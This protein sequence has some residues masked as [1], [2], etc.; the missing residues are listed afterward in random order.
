MAICLTSR[1]SRQN[2]PII[3]TIVYITSHSSNEAFRSTYFKSLCDSIET[4]YLTLIQRP[5]FAAAFQT[6]SVREKIVV[7][8]QMM[9]GLAL[10]VD[11]TNTIVIFEALSRHFT[12]LVH[13][14]DLYHSYPDVE[15][16]ILTIFRDLVK[17]QSYDALQNAYHQLLYQAIHELIQIYSKNEVGRH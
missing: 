14:L 1:F 2:S 3:Q 15:L 7:S 13:L 12:S 8:L 4:S 5:N 9:G 17:N 11:E 6:T 16:Y 10:S